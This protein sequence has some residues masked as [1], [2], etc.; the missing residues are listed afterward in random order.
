M[1]RIADD[2]PRPAIIAATAMSGQGLPDTHTP[3]PAAMTAMLAT[4]SLRVHSQTDHGEGH[5]VVCRIGKKVE[6]VGPHAD[7]A[8]DDAGD[9]LNQKHRQIDRECG[10]QNPPI[11]FIGSRLGAVVITATQ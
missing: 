8:R 3:A 2:S 1:I 4:Q 9:D 10:P 11:A 6:R 7:G 5:R